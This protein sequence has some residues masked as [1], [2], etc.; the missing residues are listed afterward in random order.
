MNRLD[1]NVARCEALFSSGLHES[2]APTAASVTA[3]IGAAV[4]RF[5]VGG[6]A[7]LMAQEFGDHPE[8]ARDRMR[9]AR[10]VVSEL[11]ASPGAGCAEVRRPAG[12]A[13][14]HAA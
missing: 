12:H 4:R 14:R 7:R 3:A 5:G 8:A 11:F 6:C 9:W 13:V 1:I 2:D 10:L